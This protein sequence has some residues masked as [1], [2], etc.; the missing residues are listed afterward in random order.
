MAAAPSDGRSLRRPIRSHADGFVGAATKSKS[1]A[2][3]KRDV[4]GR[5]KGLWGT[6]RRR[7]T[8]DSTKVSGAHRQNCR[9]N[10]KKGEQEVRRLADPRRSDSHS[11][12]YPVRP[13][14]RRDAPALLAIAAGICPSGSTSSTAPRAIASLGIPKT[15][16]VASSWAIV[17][18]PARFIVF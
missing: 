10:T 6:T 8:S 12:A 7:E 15:T 1:K 16:H 14:R 9:A 17:A 4:S 13:L 18:A 3:P 11:A 5:E 2:R